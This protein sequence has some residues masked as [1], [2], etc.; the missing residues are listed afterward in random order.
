MSVESS[1]QPCYGVYTLLGTN[2]QQVTFEDNYNRPMDSGRL[3]G[4]V[5][6]HPPLT[7]DCAA[8]QKWLSDLFRELPAK[9]PDGIPKTMITGIWNA[10]CGSIRISYQCDCEGRCR[11]ATEKI[12]RALADAQRS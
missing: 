11:H 5:W 6:G 10:H 1:A 2:D 4:E 7:S 3:W 8:T 9:S 12:T